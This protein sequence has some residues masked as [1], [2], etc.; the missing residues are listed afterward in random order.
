[1]SQS[2]TSSDLQRLLGFPF[3]DPRWKTK[4]L[5]AGAL[6]LAGMIIP[7]VPTLFLYG[8]FA[9]V[10]RRVI[11]GGQEPSLPEWDDWSQKLLDGLRLA[12]AGLVYCLPLI[13]LF[14]VGMGLYIGLSIVPLLV[15]G[16]EASSPEVALAPLVGSGVWMLVMGVAMILGLVTGAI[17]PGPIAHTV[18]KGEFAAALRF[19]EWWPIFRAN[20]GG[21]LLAYVLLMGVG[22]VL[23][24]VTQVLYL[25]IV[26][27]IL[28]PFVLAVTSVYL[29]LIA[30]VLFGQAYRTGVEKVA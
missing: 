14:L 23:S 26:L 11:A 16:A 7:I 15:A 2:F 6:M 1:M 28:A 8:Y 19:R 18:A 30:G 17:L 22:M 3:R 20:L 13:L 24:L 25:T 9:E 21:F 12:G 27:C 4:W 29:L 10:M 5:I